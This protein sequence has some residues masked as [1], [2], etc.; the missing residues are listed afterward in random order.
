MI[1]A[2]A[3]LYAICCC[4][5]KASLLCFY[6]RLSA[7]TWLKRTSLGL[8]IIQ[9]AYSTAL[10]LAL[11]FACQPL[12]KVFSATVTEGSC[13]NRTSV[14]ICIAALNIASDVVLLIMPIPVVWALQMPRMQRVGVLVV[15]LLGSATCVTSIIRLVLLLD[16]L[17]DPD[18]PWAVT[19][20]SLWV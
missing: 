12:S 7:L 9:I 18:Q 20:A 3:P 10:V 17:G 2:S 6:Y 11:F 15:F 14:Y 1:G 8:N 13:I 19:W 4:L 16:V 5:A